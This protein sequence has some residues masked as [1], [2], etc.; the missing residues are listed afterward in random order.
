M[1]MQ[2]EFKLMS[3]VHLILCKESMYTKVSCP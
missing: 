1:Q 3:R 2:I